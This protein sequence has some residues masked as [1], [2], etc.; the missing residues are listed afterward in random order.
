MLEELE[1]KKANKC[2]W[3][4]KKS[5]SENKV[6]LKQLIEESD[7]DVKVTSKVGGNN[8]NDDSSEPDDEIETGSISY[9]FKN[10]FYFPARIN[11]VTR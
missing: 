5:R 7:D 10:V 4:E 8:F 6:L 9:N 1:W 11:V 2:K 3:E